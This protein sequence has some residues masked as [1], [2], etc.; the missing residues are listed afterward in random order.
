[1][2]IAN[3]QFGIDEINRIKNIG[4]DLFDTSGV[5][6][7]P[8]RPSAELQMPDELQTEAFTSSVSADEILGYPSEGS[9]LSVPLPP[10]R[11]AGISTLAPAQV[12][13]PAAQMQTIGPATQAVQG[14]YYGEDLQQP[15][16]FGTPGGQFTE[17][18]GFPNSTA[19][20]EFQ[21]QAMRGPKALSQVMDF[22][23]LNRGIQA[24]TGKSPSEAALEGGRQSMRDILIAGGKF[25]PDT[26]RI[27]AELPSGRLQMNNLGLVTYSGMPDPNYAGPFANLVNPPEQE[28]GGMQ[29]VMQEEV[30][31][32]CPP[33]YALVDGVCQPSEQMGPVIAPEQSMGVA[34]APMSF[35]P[36]YQ[37]YQPQPLNPFV[38][39]P[40]GAALGRSV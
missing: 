18:Y 14:E 1:M 10:V 37:P 39:S 15:D 22:S 19:L 6:L 23:L 29:P 9:R 28:R 11:P 27:E 5:P 38:L 30:V 12:G 36:T 25:N 21:T 32:P 35:Q 33:G 8:T 24:L 34:P 4:A 17:L 7:P 3:Q 13:P 2:F 40:T 20:G 31:N 16:I 26:G